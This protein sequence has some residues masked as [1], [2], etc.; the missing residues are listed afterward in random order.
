MKNILFTGLLLMWLLSAAWGQEG[1]MM[2]KITL[3]EAMHIAKNESKFILLDC[4]TESCG[5]CR[6]MDREVFPLKKM[7][8][9]L[10]P[11]CIFVKCDMEKGEGPE[12]SKKFEIKG[13]P[14]FIMLNDEGGII[15]QFIGYRNAEAFLM[16]VKGAIDPSMSLAALKER[17][18][19]GDRDKSFLCDYIAALSGSRN[20]RPALTGVVEE[21]TGMLS[22]KEKISPDYWFLYTQYAPEGSANEQYLLKNRRRFNETVGEDRVN[23]RLAT[24]SLSE[25]SNILIGMDGDAAKA[26]KWAKELGLSNHPEVV[27]YK[28]A[29]DTKTNRSVDMFLTVFEKNADQVAD[30]Q[31]FVKI[32][33]YALRGTM[34]HEQKARFKTLVNDE[35]MDKLI[36]RML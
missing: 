20:D 26:D 29:V 24:K 30:I 34:S 14:T 33:C 13:Y 12:L 3:Q 21:L 18:A 17:Y 16:E 15:H 10:N 22:D 2:Q 36:D 9:Y 35:E 25:Y 7:G 8:D 28:A 19:T 31:P 27:L 5:P 11:K 32:V 6:L 4:Y 1:V 23:S